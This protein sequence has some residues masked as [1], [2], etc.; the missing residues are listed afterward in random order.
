MNSLQPKVLALAVACLGT[1]QAE[2]AYTPPVGAEVLTIDGGTPA[3]PVT[4]PLALTLTDRPAASG[5]LRGAI[6]AVSG[7]T[8]T[9]SGAGWTASALADPAYPYDVL[10]V[11][12]SGAG[13][14]LAV[15]ANT[16]DTL[17]VTG[18][19]LATLGVAVSDQYQLVPVDTL[20]SFFGSD[21]F[22]GGTDATAADIVALGEQGR[23]RYY[24]NT[25]NSRWQLVG[26]D[27]TNRGATRLPPNGMIA[28]VRKAAAFNLTL[29]GAVPITRTNIPVANVGNTYTHTGFPTAVSL[30]NLALQ[31]Q[32]TGWVSHTDTAQADLLAVATGAS[33]VNYFHNG[34]NWQRTPGSSASRDAVVIPAGTPIRIIKR[35]G[36]TGSTP[37]ILSLP[38]SL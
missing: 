11:T 29:L 28:V 23:A 24:Y 13:A 5:R 7:S 37:L 4:T 17:T 38:Y 21:T 26:G 22:L 1:A 31:D 20:D 6:T 36:T 27:A 19:D 8:L 34:T 16:A 3:A 18:R 30:G 32:L 15:T 9:V 10:L 33:W 35:N 2:V 14:R 25:T 12:G